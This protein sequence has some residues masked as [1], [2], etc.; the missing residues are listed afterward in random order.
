MN[1]EVESVEVD[2][3][4]SYVA[5]VLEFKRRWEAEHGAEDIWFRGVRDASL[6]LLPGAYWRKE[7]DEDSLFLGFKSMV[8][9]YINR[10]PLDNWEWY[11]LMQHYGLPTRLLDWTESALVGL[12]FAVAS[13]TGHETPCVWLLMPGHLNRLTHKYDKAYVITPEGPDTATWLPPVCGRRKE[14]RLLVGSKNYKDN[15]YPIAIFPKRFNPRIVAQRGT[16]TV[17]GVDETPIEELLLQVADGAPVP[18][19]KLTV[20]AGAA[21]GLRGDLRFLG[22]DR[23]AL[24]PEPS[25]VAEELKEIYQVR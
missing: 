11:Y 8:P 13:T 9:S 25:S 4:P 24:F 2:S 5:G 15:S 7:C 17:H 12:Y 1:R 10:E 20:K 3:L 16:F 22:V 6:K 14:V 19:A 21:A 23:V 18:I